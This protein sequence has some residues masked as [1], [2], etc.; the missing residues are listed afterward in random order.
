MCVYAGGGGV[1]GG[2]GGQSYPYKT[3]ALAAAGCQGSFA[4]W[5]DKT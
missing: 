5:F 4:A 2:V 3:A 1:E